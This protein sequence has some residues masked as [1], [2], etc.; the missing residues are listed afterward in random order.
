[1]TTSSLQRLVVC[2]KALIYVHA[3]SHTTDEWVLQRAGAR[4]VQHGLPSRGTRPLAKRDPAT[5]RDN[6]KERVNLPGERWKK[7]VAPVCFTDVG[8]VD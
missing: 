1:M 6:G 2:Y 5:A 3:A 8:L 7:T 4:V